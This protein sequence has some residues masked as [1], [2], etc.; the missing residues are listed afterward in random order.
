[1]RGGQRGIHRF[2]SNAYHTI[3]GRILG[4]SGSISWHLEVK[5][6]MQKVADLRVRNG[7]EGIEGRM[8]RKGAKRVVF[9]GDLVLIFV[10]RQR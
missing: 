5:F 1:M 10:N 6:K 7:G 9:C 4:V 3:W 2:D 8:C